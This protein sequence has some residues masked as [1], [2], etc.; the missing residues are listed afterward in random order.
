MAELLSASF[1]TVAKTEIQLQ[2][3]LITAQPQAVPS[4][5]P[6]VRKLCRDGAQPQ[7]VPKDTPIVCKLCRE[8]LGD[9]PSVCKLC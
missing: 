7:A 6:S 3:R 2:A 8:G 5:T 1:L 4:N 9:T